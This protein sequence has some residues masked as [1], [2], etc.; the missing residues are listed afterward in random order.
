M[1]FIN[2]PVTDLERSKRFFTEIGFRIEER[3][4]SEDVACIV[5]G[6][7]AFAMLHTPE[8]HARFD[9]RPLADTA[10]TATGIYALGLATRAEVDEIADR[11]LGAGGSATGVKSPVPPGEVALR[12]GSSLPAVAYPDRGRAHPPGSR[13]SSARAIVL[14]RRGRRILQNCAGRMPDRSR[15]AKGGRER[16]PAQ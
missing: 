15:E 9:P 4:T 8:S 2:L 16:G 10:G 3:F 13:E 5:F 12:L 6:E 14:R 11:V 1:V 7:A